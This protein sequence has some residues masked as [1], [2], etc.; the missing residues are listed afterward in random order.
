MFDALFQSF[1]AAGLGMHDAKEIRD[2][3]ERAPEA[4]VSTIG[5]LL[6]SRGSQPE[7][8]TKVLDILREAL[9][10]VPQ[11]FTEDERG[12]LIEALTHNDKDR[13][14]LVALRAELET[15]L[16]VNTELKSRLRAEAIETKAQA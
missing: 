16:T 14:E 15:A 4:A 8:L 7:F 10:D 13:A 12:Q 11:V 2:I 5:R 3:A 6:I 9:K 1:R